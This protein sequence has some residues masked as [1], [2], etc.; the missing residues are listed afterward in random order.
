M[1]ER[2]SFIISKTAS[3]NVNAGSGNAPSTG[4]TSNASQET[5]G[6]KIRVYGLGGS[7]VYNRLF[8]NGDG[9]GMIAG[10]RGKTWT[11]MLQI[12]Q[13]LDTARAAY[14]SNEM[15]IFLAHV[16]PGKEPLIASLLVS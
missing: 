7:V 13:L 10:E 6:T 11:T 12:G 4:T 9:L 8:D 1:D 3:A 15:R 16:S 14:F 2:N 5:L